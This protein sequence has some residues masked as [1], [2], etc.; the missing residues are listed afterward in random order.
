MAGW[1]DATMPSTS[2]AQWQPWRSK[3]SGCPCR[4]LA[5]GSV[6]GSSTQAR[7]LTLLSL[8]KHV[9]G[10]VKLPAPLYWTAT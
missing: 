1:L 3:L 8:A 7:S 5:L 6:T 4:H 9:F 2:R 10:P